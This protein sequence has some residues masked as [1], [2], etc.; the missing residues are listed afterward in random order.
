MLD[1]RIGIK[2]NVYKVMDPGKYL[3]ALGIHYSPQIGQ[4]VVCT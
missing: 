2:D 3:Q 1:V 4:K